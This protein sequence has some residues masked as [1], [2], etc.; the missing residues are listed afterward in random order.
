MKK[1]LMTSFLKLRKGEQM[2]KEK[3]SVGMVKK[4]IKDI[5]SEILGIGEHIEGLEKVIQAD[6]VKLLVLIA[7]KVELSADLEKLK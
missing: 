1:M 7:D 2:P 3:K 5:E 6:R 4:R